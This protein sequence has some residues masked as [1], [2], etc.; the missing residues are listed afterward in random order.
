MVQPT[1]REKRRYMHFKIECN[2]RLTEVEARE[3][4]YHALLSFIGE[5]GFSKANPKLVEFKDNSGVLMC[6]NKEV[7]SVKAA[8]ALVSKIKDGDGC[9]RVLKVSGMINRL[10][11]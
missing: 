6:S 1:M 3:E 9:V 11:D 7:P 4:L 5:L 2:R 8:L 10:N